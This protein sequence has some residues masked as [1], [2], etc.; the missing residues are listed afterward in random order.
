MEGYRLRSINGEPIDGSIPLQT[1]TVEAQQTVST[2]QTLTYNGKAAAGAVSVSS[3]PVK[4]IIEDQG[5]RV[6]S[7]WGKSKNK[8]YSAFAD[9]TTQKGSE[10]LLSVT[11]TATAAAITIYDPNKNLEELF[12]SVTGTVKRFVVKVYDKSGGTLYGWVRGVS[13]VSNVYTF[14]IMNNRLSETQSWI[15]TLS[16][17][18]NTA[19]E[20]VEVYFYNSSVAFGT[21]TCF[22]EEIECPKEYSKSRESQLIFAETLSDGQYFIDYWRGEFFGV[23]ADTTAS[24]TVTYNIWKSIAG[25]GGSVAS[26][27]DVTKIGGISVAALDRTTGQESPG[28]TANSLVTY[29]VSAAV[30]IPPTHL[31]PIDGTVANT[32]STT[33]TCSAFPFT[34]DDDNCYVTHIDYY[35]TGSTY[36]KRLINGVNGVS[37]KASSNVITVEGAGTPF[38]GGDTYNVGV[39]EQ[40]KA[41]DGINNAQYVSSINPDSLAYEDVLTTFN[42]ISATTSQTY[43]VAN[44]KSLHLLAVSSD[45]ADLHGSIDVQASYDGGTSFYPMPGQFVSMTRNMNYGWWVNVASVTHVK[46]TYTEITSTAGT[47]SLYMTR[48]FQDAPSVLLPPYAGTV[49]ESAAL[50]GSFVAG[51]EIALEGFK[52][53][54]LIQEFT[55]GATGASDTWLPE[56]QIEVSRSTTGDN[57]A[58]LNTQGVTG[59]AVTNARATF[60]PNGAANYTAASTAN[61]DIITELDN[62]GY[63]RIRVSVREGA[64]PSNQGTATIIL[65]AN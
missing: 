35:P 17:F 29:D 28:V 58:Y 53:I 56:Y 44:S 18:N 20:K 12:E 36:S 41:Y 43:N 51:K 49:R 34:V 24:E 8:V 40:K 25:G 14:E 16:A 61:K 54:A 46:I 39:R 48:S 60:K 15:G 11:E 2:S 26:E 63:K 27:V 21:G 3:V 19:L 23:R 10:W 33:I 47:V 42:A 45:T 65:T 6:G 59:G 7:Y 1:D 37:M 55:T 13:E 52:K 4:P 32:S 62:H 31:S 9:G 22:T 38:A 30:L 5:S 50:T 57:W 64:S